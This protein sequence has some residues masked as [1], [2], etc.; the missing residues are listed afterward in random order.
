M[1]VYGF[2]VGLWEKHMILVLAK[3]KKEACEIISKHWGT[4]VDKRSI[5]DV[6]NSPQVVSDTIIEV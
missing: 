4:T 6:Y 2:E 3:S 1:K 5:T